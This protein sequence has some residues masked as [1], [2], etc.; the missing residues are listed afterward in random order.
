MLNPGG[1]HA[2]KEKILFAAEDM[3]EIVTFVRDSRPAISPTSDMIAYGTVDISEETNILARRPTG[4]LWIVPTNTGKA[5]L[6]LQ[7][8]V[9]GEMPVWSPDGK[10]LAFFYKGPDGWRL[11]VWNKITES[12]KDMGKPFETR[13][14]LKPQWDKTG[15]RIVYSI[16]VKEKKLSNP[17]RVQEIKSSDERI[18]GDWFFVNKQKASLAIIDVHTGKKIDLL[19]DPIYLRSFTVS[20]DTR[21]LIYTAPNPESFAVIRKEYNETFVVSLNGGTPRKVMT[22]NK[23]QRFMWAPDGK[24]LLFLEKGK[25]MTI[26]PE[27]GEAKPF[28]KKV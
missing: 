17:S 23:R 15:K 25:L 4:F 10:Q 22:S 27:E 18:P 28:L 24:Q 2:D 21:N 19:P 1:L 8:G 26:P 13:N 12:I 11:A 20:P 5:K 16:P 3:L 14:Y 7:K 6:L 9:H